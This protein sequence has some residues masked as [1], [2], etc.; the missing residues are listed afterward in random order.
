[1]GRPSIGETMALRDKLLGKSAG[2]KAQAEAE[3]AKTALQTPSTPRTAIGQASAFQLTIAE[4][5]RELQA[6]MASKSSIEIDI[7]ELHEVPGRKRSLTLEQFNDLKGNLANN[8]LTSPVTVRKREQGGYE[9]IA[10]HNRIQAFKDLGRTKI[11]SV[12]LDFTDD[13]ADRSAFYS[14]LLAPSLPDFEKYL[15]FSERAKKMKFTQEQLADEAGISRQLVGFLLSYDH[16]PADALTVLH[17][18]ED[19]SILGATAAQKLASLVKL[20]KQDRVTDAVRKLATGE[21]SQ[22]AAVAYASERNTQKLRKPES[23]VIRQ[24]KKTFCSISKFT[25]DLRL[26]F[27]SEDDLSDELIEKIKMV[28]QGHVKEAE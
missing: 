15:G 21:L 13:E 2:I 8:P 7:T 25:K 17:E 16:L 28:I 20:G 22:S 19:K 1:M 3:L 26:S 9:I 10:G 6:M 12:V 4:K 27:S 24:G 18:A 5:D 14:N 23:I 11:L